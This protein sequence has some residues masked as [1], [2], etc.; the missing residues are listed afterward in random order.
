MYCSAQSITPEIP[1]HA[2]ST[3]CIFLLFRAD[4]STP[5][6]LLPQFQRPRTLT[7]GHLPE[8]GQPDGGCDIRALFCFFGGGGT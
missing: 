2:C 4:I 1:T 7:S 5:V 3:P 8:V 6:F